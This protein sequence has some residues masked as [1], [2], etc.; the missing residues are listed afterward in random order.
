MSVEEAPQFLF[1]SASPMRFSISV[2]GTILSLLCVLHVR[3][4]VNECAD[5]FGV[6]WTR[7][8][9]RLW[10]TPIDHGG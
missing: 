4:V 2:R 1:E 7:S 5:S 10:R 8:E 9:R 6:R 3:A